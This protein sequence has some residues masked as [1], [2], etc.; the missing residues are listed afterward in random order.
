[1]KS[2]KVLG[3]VTDKDW[4]RVDDETIERVKNYAKPSTIKQLMSFNGLVNWM[5][6]YLPNLGE[7]MQPL[8]ELTK[9][10]GPDNREEEKLDK[11]TKYRHLLRTRITRTPELTLYLRK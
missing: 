4:R 11:K 6:D 1:M 3:R 7:K 5:R 2:L 10:E 8:Y 9:I